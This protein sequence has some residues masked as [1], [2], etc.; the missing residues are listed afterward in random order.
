[1]KNNII[2]AVYELPPMERTGFLARH[3]QQLIDKVDEPLVEA[4]ST[5]KTSVESLAE[6]CHVSE[7]TMRKHIRSAGG[8][9]FKLGKVYWIRN[10][11]LARVYAQLER[12]QLA[13]EGS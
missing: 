10:M 7:E 4:E 12:S 5:D 9:L 1:M 8:Y 6:E 3:I 11:H 2:E 13:K